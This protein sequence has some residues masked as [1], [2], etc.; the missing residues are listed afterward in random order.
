MG[1]VASRTAFGCSPGFR[2]AAI[3]LG[4][5]M[6]CLLARVDA[7]AADTLSDAL[8][9]MGMQDMSLEAVVVRHPDVF[10]VEAVAQSKQS[11]DALTAPA[12]GDATPVP[13]S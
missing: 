3:R 5:A 11:L 9:K 10:S 8:V 12:A 2:I 6:L 13:A 7:S 4:C 1:G